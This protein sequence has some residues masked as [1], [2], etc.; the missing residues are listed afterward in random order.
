M[1]VNY[2]TYTP[3]N[4]IDFN[5]KLRALIDSTPTGKQSQK[6]PVSHYDGYNHTKSINANYPEFQHSRHYATWHEP[7]ARTGYIEIP[8]PEIDKSDDQ[9]YKI[10]FWQRVAPLVKQ[11]ARYQMNYIKS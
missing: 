7:E 6:Q 2:W 8:P 4:H 9:I 1:V 11:F 3:S 10:S 5:D